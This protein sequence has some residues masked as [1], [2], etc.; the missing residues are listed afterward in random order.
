MKLQKFKN[1]SSIYTREEDFSADIANHISL[2]SVGDFEDA[3]TESK[4]GT[5]KADIV[6]TGN[7]GILV[8]ENQL[9]KADWDH[10]GR[11]EAYARLKEANIAVLIAEEFEELMIVTCNLRNEDSNIDWYLIQAQVNERDE[12]SFHQIARPAIDVQTERKNVEYSDFW[13]PIRRE[14]LFAG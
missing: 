5:R 3:E 12:F 14:C 13:E 4:V 7:D 1:L 10:W 6:A 8:I 9:G 11:L 2:L